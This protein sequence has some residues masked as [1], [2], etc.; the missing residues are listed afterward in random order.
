MA[1][2]GKSLGISAEQ[3]A[4]AVLEI[5][6]ADMERALRRVSLARGH[7]ARDFALYAF[8]GAGGLHAAW[9]AARL[10][11]TRVVMPPQAGVFSALGMLCAP[12]RRTLV[13]S[14]LQTLPAARIR[15]EYFRPLEDQ[16]R[17]ELVS[18]G[19]ARSRIRVRRIL[20][21]RSEGQAG[22]FALAEGPALLER[23]HAEHERRFGYRREEH[24]VL[25]V[26]VRVHAEG[27]SQSPWQARRV[28]T[29][30]AVPFDVRNAF[31]PE[32]GV[33]KAV[34]TNWYRREDMSPGS[35]L[36][37]P[38][39]VAEYSGTTVVPSD[40]IARVDRWGALELT[41]EEAR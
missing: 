25:L 26:A 7:D 10:G 12:A 1:A 20:E 30:A 5:A 18:E 15:K 14:V 19:V 37:G 38:A 8:G 9:V 29:K 39:V 36:R 17:A 28:R 3:A 35:H 22:E 11:M 4:V 27:P 2:L 32:Q 33:R 16:A 23:F 41:Q 21:L 34:L 6:S 24:A 13:Q 31:L 40:W